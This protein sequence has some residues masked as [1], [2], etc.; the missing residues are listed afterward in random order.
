MI[1]PLVVSGSNQECTFL[2]LGRWA[3]L[4]FNCTTSSQRSRPGMQQNVL[5]HIFTKVPNL[6]VCANVT[7]SAPNELSFGCFIVCVRSQTIKSSAKSSSP[8][9]CAS[10]C[11][12]M[13]IRHSKSACN[14]GRR[15]SIWE[16]NSW[17][18]WRISGFPFVPRRPLQMWDGGERTDY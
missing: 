17:F 3:W 7:F 16:T 12:E 13:T 4:H 14:S 15:K 18:F 1:E 11:A 10:G 8:R 6:R 9:L 2:L 5:L